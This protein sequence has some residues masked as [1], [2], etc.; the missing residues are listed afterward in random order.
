MINLFNLRNLFH[1]GIQKDMQCS[2]IILF[3]SL[4]LLEI[5]KRF[6][7]KDILKLVKNIN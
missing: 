4:A 7:S 6:F 2:K 1:Y 5:L 3:N